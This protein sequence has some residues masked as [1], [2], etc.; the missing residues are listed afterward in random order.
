MPDGA[1]TPPALVF[2]AVR[3]GRPH[4]GQGLAG[5]PD[6]MHA[7]LGST[8]GTTYAVLPL[9]TDNQAPDGA[10]LL[11]AE[12]ESAVLPAPQAAGE[13]LLG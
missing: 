8:A 4:F 7:W 12:P 11:T 3:S 1:G 13:V 5:F 6:P 9:A 2:D 10:L